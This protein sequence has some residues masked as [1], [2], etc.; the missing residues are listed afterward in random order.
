M[1]N[2]GHAVE[3]ERG[4]G[5]KRVPILGNHP[6]QFLY[7][8]PQTYLI[9]K[10]VNHPCCKILFDLYHQQITE[11]N[12]IPNIDR[13]WSQIGCFQVG[14]SPGR[15]EPTT[16]EINYKNIFKHLHEKGWN[17]IVG[18]EH[19]ISQE[20]IAGEQR[21][22][23]RVDAYEQIP[24]GTAGLIVDSSGLVSVAIARGS[25]AAELGLG[26][27]IEV[28]LRPLDEGDRGGAVTPVE[29]GRR[30]GES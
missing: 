7:G 17:G 26:E 18:M 9:C 24:V 4:P 30:N 16:G 3:D 23:V 12:L 1:K 6:G 27:A 19:G 21:L 14:D 25:A 5:F 22:A 2:V 28:K 15:K 8:M 29:L 11:G 20:G 10:A 13:A